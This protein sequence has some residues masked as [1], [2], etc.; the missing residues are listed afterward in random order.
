MALW[1]G[2]DLDDRWIARAKSFAV[3]QE[4]Q[5][6]STI[7]FPDEELVYSAQK[8][9]ADKPGFSREPFESGLGIE[10]LS[11]SRWTAIRPP[12]RNGRRFASLWRC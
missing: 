8:I 3:I 5:Y 2:T 7:Q 12:A 4:L 11:I 1:C 10:D 6:W 9:G